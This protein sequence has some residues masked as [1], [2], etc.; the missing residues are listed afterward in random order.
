MKK[1]KL[2]KPCFPTLTSLDIYGMKQC[3]FA[4]KATSTLRQCLRVE[5]AFLAPLPCLLPFFHFIEKGFATL[6]L[7]S[8]TKTCSV[9]AL[10]LLAV[11]NILL[12]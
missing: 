1:R 6:L 9:S 2:G 11:S 10:C 12:T 3:S 5:N 4:R 7:L 8:D